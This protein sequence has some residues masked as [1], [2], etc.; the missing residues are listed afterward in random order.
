[1]EMRKLGEIDYTVEISLPVSMLEP[2]SSAKF[3]V[4]IIHGK[5]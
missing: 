1:M 3:S 5:S 2:Y 4:I